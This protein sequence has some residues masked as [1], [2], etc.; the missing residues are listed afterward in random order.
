MVPTLPLAGIRSVHKSVVGS[1]KPV[2][3]VLPLCF[4]SHFSLSKVT[5]H[6]ALQR[7]RMPMR[8]AMVNNGTMCPVKTIGR[9]GMLMS[10]TCVEHIFLPSGKLIVRGVRVTCLLLTGAPSMMKIGIAPVS[11]MAW[12]VANVK[13][14]RYCGIGAPYSALTVDARDGRWQGTF[15]C[16]VVQFDV[17]TV[18]SSSLLG[19]DVVR[20][21]GSR[22]NDVA[23]MTWLHL[24]AT[25]KD[26][27][28]HR[29]AN[30]FIERSV[31]CTPRWQ[32]SCPPALYC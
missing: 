22:D 12:L 1:L 14:L 5:V 24:C 21:V 11:A 13:A 32:A 17:T 3:I 9:P 25:D 7:G 6:P 4:T 30:Q 10:H 2:Q 18:L 16:F 29:Q 20:R 23:K 8:D 19:D 26:S 31:L 15:T 28:P 27:A